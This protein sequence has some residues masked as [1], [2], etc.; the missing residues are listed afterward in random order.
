MLTAP[1][2]HPG[3]LDDLGEEQHGQ[4]IARRR[5]EHDRVARGDRRRDL[6]ECEVEGEIE[7]RDAGDG[8]DGES[9][10]DAGA[11]LRARQQVERDDFALHP[12]RFL[13]G[14]LE[15]EDAAIGFDFR[16]PDRLAGFGGDHPRDFVAALLESGG[17]RLE[18]GDSLVGRRLAG[19]LERPLRADDRLLELVAAGL[20]GD[21]D[22]V[23]GEGVADGKRFLR[24]LPFA[25]DVDRI[26]L[27]AGRR[28]GLAFL[29]GGCHADA[30][31]CERA[32]DTR[33]HDTTRGLRRGPVVTLPILVE[34]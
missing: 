12:L 1:F 2:G 28:A 33:W 7:W 14:G 19:D 26:A 25:G 31:R 16:V 22:D 29:N 10:H 23:T 21:A 4:R 34:C 18:L 6:V 9:P 8:T 15:G 20:V 3:R 5:L 11:A 24:G 17:H 13:G 32:R 30:F 27:G